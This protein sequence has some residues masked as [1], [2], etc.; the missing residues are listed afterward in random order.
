MSWKKRDIGDGLGSERVFILSEREVEMIM[1]FVTGGMNMA[2]RK[3]EYYRDIRD[4]GE[5]TERQLTLMC[6]W[7]ERAW[8][9]K[10]VVGRMRRRL[11]RD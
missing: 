4:G 11:I 2:A 3:A 5:A 7:E 6:D 9:L 8:A 1:P 10:C